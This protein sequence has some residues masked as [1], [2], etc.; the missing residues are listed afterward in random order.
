MYFYCSFELGTT[1]SPAESNLLCHFE[2]PEQPDATQNG[3]AERRHH[4]RVRQDH[5]G[6]RADHDEA[7]EPIEQRDKVTLDRN[8]R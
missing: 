8:K 3:N 4:V 2:H 6:N 5:L 7:V 1:V